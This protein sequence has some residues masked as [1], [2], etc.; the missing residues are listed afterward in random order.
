MLVGVGFYASAILLTLLSASCMTVV[1]R[2]EAWLPSR[3]AVSVTLVFRPDYEPREDVLRRVALERGYEVAGGSFT[4]NFDDKR[5]EWR[6]VAVALGK[7]PSAGKTMA[8]NDPAV[9][10]VGR[11]HQPVAHHD[12]KDRKC[13]EEIDVSVPLRRR[14]FR[15]GSRARPQ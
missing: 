9:L 10:H 4:I 3:P 13:P 5:P 12:G 7:G 6:F 14:L 2:I 1:S 8:A 11:R 15:Q